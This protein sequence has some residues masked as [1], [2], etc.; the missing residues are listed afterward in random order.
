[1]NEKHCFGAGLGGWVDALA[2]SSDFVGT[3]LDPEIAVRA[4]EELGVLERGA[5]VG[6]DDGIGLERLE[7]WDL[8]RH[9]C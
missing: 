1:M 7:V 5:G 3:G 9:C 2:E 4:W 8:E 6:I